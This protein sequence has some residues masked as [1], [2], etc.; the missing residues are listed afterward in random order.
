MEKYKYW[1][2]ETSRRKE[3]VNSYINGSLKQ[4]TTKKNQSKNPTTYMHKREKKNYLNSVD[5]SAD[6]VTE[7][8]P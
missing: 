5:D 1:R 4:Q 2:K 8:M 6:L 7:L 3:A